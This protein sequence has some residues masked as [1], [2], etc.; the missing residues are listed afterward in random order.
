MFIIF[1][2]KIFTFVR[3]VAEIVRR[4]RDPGQPRHR[5]E[6]TRRLEL[7]TRVRAMEA[8]FVDSACKTLI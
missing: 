7:L 6:E 8:A 2:S 1:F 4:R 3:E 5:G